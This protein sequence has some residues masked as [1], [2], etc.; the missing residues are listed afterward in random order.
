[1]FAW[2]PAAVAVFAFLPSRLAVITVFLIGWLFLPVASFS[3]PGI[4]NYS[5]TVAVSLSVMIGVVLF[6]S[7]RLMT[8]RLRWLDLPMLI[9]CLCPFA[10]SIANML[11]PY[12]GLAAAA[13]NVLTWGIPY[14]VG[15]L[16]FSDAQGIKLLALGIVVGGLIYVPLCVYEIRMSP[17]LHKIIYG[18]HQHIF[19]QT[20]RFGGWRP[21]VFLDHGLMLGSWMASAALISGW[22]WLTG[23]QRRL[24]KV[25]FGLVFLVLLLTAIDVKSLGALVLLAIGFAVLWISRWLQTP[26]LILCLAVVPAIYGIARV[27]TGWSASELVSA[28]GIVS[29]D[30]AE[31]LAYRVRSEAILVRHA[32]QRPVLGWGG[33]GRHRVR[34]ETGRDI[35][36][37]DSLWIIA[38]GQRGWIGLTAVLMLMSA[39]VIAIL[40][41]LPACH[42]FSTSGAPVLVL[43]VVLAL[44]AID[45]LFNAMINPIFILTMGSVTGY[46]QYAQRLLQSPLHAPAPFQYLVRSETD[47]PLR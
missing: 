21:M 22:L 46:A 47:S 28:C 15:R 30:R 40:F 44:H 38:L 37:T 27:V 41:R 14:F 11:G 18:Y 34:D 25:S 12:D 5:K 1:M 24:S 36:I 10:S 45:C 35:A 19:L 4:P 7:Q 29:R 2:I 13:A 31:S 17:Q 26:L 16:Y 9:W 33:W 32:M 42:L 43:A 8:L 39:P 6:D 23:S 20:K 3:L